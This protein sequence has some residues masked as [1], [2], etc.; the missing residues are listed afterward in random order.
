MTVRFSQYVT[1]REHGMTPAQAAT[2]AKEVSVNFD[3]KG[4]LRLF[5]GL[6]SFFNA[7]MQG[8]NKMI[9][10]WNNG[11]KIGL[12]LYF[13]AHVASG[14]LNTLLMP[15]DPE[16]EKGYGEYDRMINIVIGS[17]RIPLPQGLRAFHAIGVQ[18]ALAMQGQKTLQAAIMDALSFVFG[19][20]LPINPIDGFYIDPSTNRL[21]YRADLGFR[22]FVPTFAT[23][24][25]D[26]VTNTTYSGGTVHREPFV[27]T[28]DVPATMLSKKV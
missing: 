15:D 18:I 9:R 23:P 24:I 20:W 27:K 14:V 1:A 13:S 26:V 8:S 25:Y 22:S 11:H 16:D 6:F 3:R 12:A 5:Y 17:W 4:K 10:Q 2:E 21:R 7:T 28:L 19:E